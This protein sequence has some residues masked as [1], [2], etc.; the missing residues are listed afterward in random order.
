MPLLDKTG[1]ELRKGQLVDVVLNGVFSGVIIDIKEKAIAI[2]RSQM[3]P[4]QIA[5]QVLVQH[6]PN[7]GVHTGVYVIQ[8]P[9]TEQH[10]VAPSG[11]Q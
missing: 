8:E 1:K 5:I 7:D 10:I 11:V 4:P 2:N 3:A 9:E 6:V